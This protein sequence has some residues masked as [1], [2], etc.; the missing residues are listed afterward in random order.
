MTYD[1][2]EAA[3]HPAIRLFTELLAVPSPPGHEKAM[4][5]RI[6]AELERMGFAYSAD[7]SGNL[8]VPLDCDAPDRPLTVMAAHMDELGLTVVGIDP[9][10]ALRVIPS[11]RLE[12]FK[13]GERPMVVLGTERL[14][15]GVLSL[16]SSHQ[17]SR[18][19]PV[20][21]RD[22]RVITGLSPEALADAG[23]RVG[24]TMTVSCEAR[25]PVFLGDPRD[26]LVAAWTFDDRMGCVALLR[27]LDAIR[28]E[29]IRPR[30][31][32]LVAFT[33]HEEGSCHGAMSLCQ[34]LQPEVFLAVDGCPVTADMPL[35]L[36]GRPAVWSRDSKAIYDPR[37]VQT[38]CRLAEKEGVE[39]QHAVYQNAASDASAAYAVGAVERVAFMGHVREN[40]HGYEVARL[41]V[42]DRVLQVLRRFVIEWE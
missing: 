34:R 15:T 13:T 35:T 36:D 33:T 11:G 7:G 14:V 12:V 41:S 2:S 30:R 28:Q 23:V 18:E 37:L 9:D 4:A 26:P 10:G 19:A 39:L 16:G 29:K 1:F 42:F 24:S 3:A 25:G 40:S 27:L 21:W 38:L 31:P 22:A 32:I 17:A 5:A 6:G 8:R 20:S